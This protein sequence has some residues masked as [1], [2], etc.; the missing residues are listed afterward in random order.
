MVKNIEIWLDSAQKPINSPLEPET[1]THWA[2]KAREWT[3]EN[4]Q[5]AEVT[6]LH[7]WRQ[8]GDAS[9]YSKFPC[10]SSN[11]TDST[12]NQHHFCAFLH[13]FLWVPETSILPVLA[14]R[15]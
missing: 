15:I 12:S 3:R 5:G 8:R 2:Q 4:D 10:G 6:T 1:P 7:V 11:R 13:M 9:Y 14:L